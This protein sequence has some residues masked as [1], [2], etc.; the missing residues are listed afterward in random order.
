MCLIVILYVVLEYVI[1]ARNYNFFL[2]SNLSLLVMTISY[3]VSSPSKQSNDSK[4]DR[5]SLLSASS[6]R[7]SRNKKDVLSRPDNKTGK[8]ILKQQRNKTP[9]PKRQFG[10]LHHESPYCYDYVLRQNLDLLKSKSTLVPI[11]QALQKKVK[12]LQRWY[13]VSCSCIYKFYIRAYQ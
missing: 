4:N 1:T 7:S 8:I 3:A 13:L 5:P 11:V 6:V 12:Y 9:M 2:V 10:S